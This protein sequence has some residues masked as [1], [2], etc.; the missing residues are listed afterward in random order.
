KDGKFIGVLAIDILTKDLQKEYEANPGRTFAFDKNNKIFAA[1]DKEQL[2]EGYNIDQIAALSKTKADFEPFEYIRKKDGSRGL[3]M[4]VKVGE[5]RVC[6]GQSINKI[7][8]PINKM[9]YI[10][11]AIILIAIVINFILI[12]VLAAKLLSPLTI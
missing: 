9:S 2:Q 10:Q 11:I 6:T 12:Y 3:A 8:E 5:N 1:T 4:C 7:E